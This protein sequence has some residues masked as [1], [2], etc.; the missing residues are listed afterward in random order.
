MTYWK[1]LW[2]ASDR[3]ATIHDL[4]Y[5]LGVFCFIFWLNH[6]I[7]RGKGLTPEWNQAAL[8]FAGL[9][10]GAQVFGVFADR[11]TKKKDDHDQA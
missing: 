7:Y 9:V 1:R 2:D 8:T 5:M 11:G 6:G 10:G 4:A 3:T